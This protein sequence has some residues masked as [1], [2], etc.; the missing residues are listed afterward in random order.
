MDLPGGSAPSGVDTSVPTPRSADGMEAGARHMSADEFRHWGHLAV[1]WI[2]AYWEGLPDRP[3]TPPVTPGQIADRLP[4]QAPATG[5]EFESLLEDFDRLIVPGLAHWQHPGFLGFFPMTTS[6]PAVLAQM[7]TA[8]LNTQGMTWATSPAATELEQRVMD[9]LAD[10][11][12]LPDRFGG[13]GVIQDTA[14]S[15]MVVALAAALWRRAG[16][17]WRDHGSGS[18]YTVYTSTEANCSALKAARL[19]GLGDLQLRHLDVD[20]HTRALRPDGLRRAIEADLS[21]GL[22]PVAVIATI[23]TTSTTAIDPLPAIGDIC[24]DHDLWLHVDGAYAGV[25][26]ICRE[27]RWI[28]SGLEHADSY[29]VNTHKWLLTGFECSPM[30]FADPTVVTQ[31]LNTAPSYLRD[32]TD[33][34]RKAPDYRDWQ[35]PLGHPFRALK[36]W[37]TLRWYG[38][39]GLRAHLRQGIEHARLFAEMVRGDERF[40]VAAPHPFGLVCFRLRADD[41]ANALL[42]RRLNATGDLFLSSTEV[43]GRFTL[44]LAAGG[45]ATTEDHI[46]HAWDRIRTEATDLGQGG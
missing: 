14:S 25:A 35:V 32:V 42:L 5:E 38:A 17:R 10:L 36:L 27:M 18:R 29:S 43:A 3:V 26:A 16:D 22:V 7:L 23:G 2:A 1:D 9:W 28:N 37:F 13:G 46:R 41:A 33:D 19:C 21:A 45:T 39:E 6:G 12:G 44:R 15:A 20:P 24:R 31:A 30:W 40:E 11:M 8:G 34:A 4:P